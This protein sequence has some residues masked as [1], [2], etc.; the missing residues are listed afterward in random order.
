MRYTHPPQYPIVHPPLHEMSL[1]ELISY[2]PPSIAEIANCQMQ[3]FDE[4]QSRIDS[5]MMN[6]VTFIPEPL[7]NSVVYE[8][9][10]D[11][12]KVTL[13]NEQFLSDHYIAQVT[14]PA[15]T[16]SLPF[17]T[18][19]EP[20]DTLLME[21]EDSS[22]TPTRETD[23][24]IKSSANYLVPIPRESEVTSGNN[25]EC[26][27]PVTVLLPTTDVREENFDINLPLGEPV[28]N[29]LMENKDITDLPRQLVKQLFSYLVKHPSSTKRMSDE[30]LGDDLKLRS[31]D[32]TFSNSLFD[33]NEYFTLCND[34]PLFDEEFEDISI[35]DPPKSASLN[36]E[37]LGNLDSMSRSL[38]TSDLN[39]E[40]LTTKIGLD[41]FIP[42]EIDD[43]YYDSE[44]DILFLEH[45]LIEETFSDPTPAVLPKSE[46]TRVMKTS[47]FGFNYMPSPRP[48]AYSPKEVM[49]CFNP[50]VEIPFNES[51]VHIEVLSVLWGNRLPIPDGSLPLSR[52]R[53]EKRKSYA[54]LKRKPMEFQ[55][56]DKVMLK[57]SPWKGVVRFGK[58]GKLNPRVHNTFHVSNLKKCYADEPLA[59]P[60]DGLH[61]DDKLQF[62]E[63]PVEIMD[64][65]VKQLR[66]SRVPIV[67]VAF[68]HLRDAFSVVFGLSL[69]QDTVMS[70]S[71]DSMVTYTAMSSQF[72]DLPDIGSPGVDGPPV[73]PEDPYAYV[74]AAFQAPLYPDYVPGPEYPPSPDFV[75]EPVYPEFMPP[76][77]EILPAEEQPLPA[78]ASPTADSP[79]YVSESDPEE[80]PEEDDDKDPEE[81][82][83]DY[84]AVGGD[85]DDDEDESSDDEEDD[86]VDIKE[87]E[88]HPAPADSIAVALPAVDQAPSAKET[89]P[90]ETDESAATPP[91]HPAYRVTARISIRDE[92][93]ISLPPR[94]EVER[95]L[96]M[97]TLPSS[98][99]SPWS[100][101]LP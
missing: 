5:M 83:T 65:E 16:P 50:F 35:L 29:F 30:P 38:E 74:V 98:P 3:H 26:D 53:Q 27:M 85:D 59:I 39:L 48:A 66:Q 92:T 95:L 24:F 101:P 57:V 21:D 76:E 28:V 86:D 78:A 56:G 79:G 37:P 17:L 84:P 44:G 89:G 42:T 1:Q 69:T 99:L 23:E 31:Y 7:V 52:T 4:M 51:K 47:S 54:N 97:P 15:Y 34:N 100:S 13:N 87:E 11:D 2:M 25:L 62:V 45:L 93:P 60:L 58:R 10:D 9:S 14:P 63:E 91:P 94:E 90:F 61:V 64:R 33:F 80:D 82:P 67:K 6:I 46:K 77:D 96:A 88:E 8:E 19:M 43:G 70:D 36:Y 40:E 75:P 73:M 41:D 18:T 71:E 81:D 12:I 20:A 55:V 68:R 49:Y 72:A 32:V 22:T